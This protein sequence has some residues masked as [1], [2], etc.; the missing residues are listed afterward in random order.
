MAAAVVLTVMVVRDGRT[1]RREGVVLVAAYG[2]VV[3]G[4]L[5]AGNR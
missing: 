3:L 4:F 1:S 5:L 2:L